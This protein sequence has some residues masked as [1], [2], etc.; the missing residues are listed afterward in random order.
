[1]VRGLSAVYHNRKELNKDIWRHIRVV[2]TILDVGSGIRPQAFFNARLHYC[3]E[4]C[5]EY[6]GIL[7]KRYGG[8]GRIKI[9][10]DTVQNIMPIIKPQS[11]DSIFFLDVLEHLLKPDGAA[12]LDWACMVAKQQVI[13]ST[14]LGFREQNYNMG[15]KDAWGLHGG[16][17]QRHLSWWVPSNFYTDGW[18]VLVCERYSYLDAGKVYEAP[19]GVMWAVWN[20]PQA[21]QVKSYAVPSL[22]TRLQITDRLIDKWAWLLRILPRGLSDRLL[23]LSLR[24]S[25]N[26]DQILRRRRLQ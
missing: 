13:V 18:Q 22:L 19:L 5:E 26:V 8:E 17:W 2:D 16:Q 20:N 4:P 23:K 11:I 10:N 21:S 12:A 24:L 9:I 15:E 3:I 6:V 14:P 1:M 7:L 25:I